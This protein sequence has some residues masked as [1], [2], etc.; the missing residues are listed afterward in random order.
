MRAA[1]GAALQRNKT[2]LCHHCNR[3][4]SAVVAR[5][6]LRSLGAVLGTV[7][8]PSDLDASDLEDH[9]SATTFKREASDARG[10]RV[11]S[12]AWSTA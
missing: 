7:G 9:F 11:M 1:S 2:Q 3:C 4:V 12:L 6:S 5:G 8:E 10:K